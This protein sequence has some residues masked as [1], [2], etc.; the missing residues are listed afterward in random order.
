[1]DKL[2]SACFIG[3]MEEAKWLLP[4][5]VV[6]KKN[7]KLRIYVD[8]GWFNFATKKNPYPLPFIEKVLDKLVGHK[9]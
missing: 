2:L 6:L 3:P 9:V 8:F 4:I 1:L 5:V 7:D